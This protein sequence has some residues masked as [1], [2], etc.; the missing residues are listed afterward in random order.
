VNLLVNS[1]ALQA[2]QTFIP[3][4]LDIKPVVPTRQAAIYLHRKSQTIRKWA[5]VEKLRS[6]QLFIQK[7][8]IHDWVSNIHHCHSP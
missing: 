2:A 6:N 4:A 1:T 8:K 5:E 7:K 3:L